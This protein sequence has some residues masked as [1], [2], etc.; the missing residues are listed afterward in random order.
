MSREVNYFTDGSIVRFHNQDPE[1]GAYGF[2]VL[3]EDYLIQNSFVGYAYP[4]NHY[5]ECLG[6]GAALSDILRQPNNARY[7]I[8]TDS[9]T[10]YMRIKEYLENKKVYWI[11]KANKNLFLNE[12][13]QTANIIESLV[14]LK[15]DL[16]I[17]CVK[18]HCN[19]T[20]EQR[21]YLFRQGIVITKA[22][23]VFIN[24]GNRLVDRL[25]NNTATFLDAYSMISYIER[26]IY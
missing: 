9:D 18:S 24:R 5:L 6:I 12:A 11:K 7:T 17:F 19:D 3:A 16:H 26:N 4:D 14:S 10:A 21:D 23:A 2:V 20:K 22:E 25:V 1:K 15:Y 13:I 8:Y